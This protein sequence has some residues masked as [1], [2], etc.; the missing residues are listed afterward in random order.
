MKKFIFGALLVFA[1][2]S[3]C[4]TNVAETTTEE[5]DTTIV[6]DAEVEKAETVDT[7]EVVE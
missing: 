6:V 7:T 5:V 2:A 3:C 1:M 4:Q